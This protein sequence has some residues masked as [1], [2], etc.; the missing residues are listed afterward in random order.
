M[1]DNSDFQ[2]LVGTIKEATDL[3]A[4]VGETVSLKKSGSVWAGSSPWR[5]E[6]DPSLRVW[7]ASQS[8]HD[9]SGGGG[10]GGDCVEWVKKRDGCEFMEALRLLAAQAGIRLP[11]QSDADFKDAARAAAESRRVAVL[12][13]TAAGYYHRVLPDEIRQTVLK[14]GY[15]LTDE[16]IDNLYIGYSNGELWDM[17]VDTLGVSEEDALLTGLFVRRRNGGRDYFQNRVIFPYWAGGQVRYMI[18]RQTDMTPSSDYERAKYKKLRTH[19]DD[20]TYISEHVLNSWFYNEDAARWGEG[21][22]LITEG[23]TDAIAAM[24]AGIRVTS[25]VTTRFKASDVPRL[26]KLVPEK[27]RIVICN[28][29]DPPTANGQR[30]GLAGALKTAKILHEEGRSVRLATLPEGEGGTKMDVC[31]YLR[32][33]GA[34][35][36][37][38]VLADARSYPVFLLEQIAAET[39]HED[40]DRALADACRAASACGDAEKQAFAKAAAERFGLGRR[41]VAGM[42]RRAAQEVTQEKRDSVG[43]KMRGEIWQD[44]KRNRYLALQVGKVVAV[45]SFIVTP[46]RRL[47]LDED[48]LWDVTFE[49]ETGREIKAELPLSAFRSRAALLS[50]LPSGDTQWAGSDDNAQG[51]LRLLS[52]SNV[53]AVPATRVLGYVASNEDDPQWAAPDLESEI[54]YVGKSSMSSR[55]RYGKRNTTDSERVVR[56]AFPLLPNLNTQEAM[57]PMLGWFMAAGVSPAV[58]LALGHFPMLC[59]HGQPGA[60][61]TSLAQNIFWP[62]AGMIDM[63]PF[64]AGQTEF[65]TLKLLSSVSSVPIV[66]DEYKPFT[67]PRGRRERLHQMLHELYPGAAP[68]RGRADQTTVSYPLIAP[69]CLVGESRPTIPALVE[70][71]VTSRPVRDAVADCAEAYATCRS[72]P[73]HAVAAD[74]VSFW[75]TRNVDKDL[76]WAMSAVG[77]TLEGRGRVPHRVADNLAV[78]VLGLLY[79]EEFAAAMGVEVEEPDLAL[80]CNAILA[81]L[82]EGA[83]TV[84][85][86]L[87][88]FLEELSVMAVVGR[89]TRGREWCWTADGDLAIHFGG[90]HSAFAEHAKRI[91]KHEVPDRISLRRQ[92]R[93][94]V[95]KDSGYVKHAAKGIYFGQ[96]SDRRRAMVVDLN[97]A[98]L[99][100]LELDGFTGGSRQPVEDE[101]D[102]SIPL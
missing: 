94:E 74:L 54:A 90:A 72:L 53:D 13:T 16:T 100:G 96:S 98:K 37:R 25:P 36:L 51:L 69:L 10:L 62:L 33:F 83:V 65:A 32:D 73:L 6:K 38:E 93:D 101:D 64:S 12:L 40:L 89:L 86:P 70:R 81:D 1:V 60:G 84:K 97:L 49:S 66:M 85:S 43:P 15:G 19:S 50:R 42:V 24:Q 46:H 41:T 30:P 23:V 52:E 44:P 56:E 102:E 63:P 68:E 29:N 47:V 67:M 27:T 11:E 45:S 92:V 14:Q 21:D 17:M 26:L 8:W 34:D 71:M 4:L 22:L 57:L 59:V 80:A 39:P 91:E 9:F 82:Y 35:A 78:V 18:G 95:G 28:D 75:L 77:S 5:Q 79:Y 20:A 58:R 76:E 3:V 87:D 55:V 88:L 99:R 31:E 48:E 7:A 2:Q 61:K